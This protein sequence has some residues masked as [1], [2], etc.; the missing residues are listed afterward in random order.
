MSAGESPIG[1]KMVRWDLEDLPVV[2]LPAGFQLRG[3]QEGD[4]EIW[5]QIHLAADRFNEIPPSLFAQQFGSEATMLNQRQ[6]YL[7]EESGQVIGTGTAWFNDNFQGQ[8]FGRI[9]WVA[10]LPERQGRG[11]A[12]PLMS[13]LCRRLRELGHTRAYLSTSSARVPAIRLYRQFGFIPLA[14]DEQQAAAWRRLGV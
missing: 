9:H 13:A 12:K 4:Q 3:Y 8:R 7:L 2:P 5:R 11:L 14:E 1:L 6:L 10:L